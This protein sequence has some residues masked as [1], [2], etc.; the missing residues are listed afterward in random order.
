MKMKIKIKTALLLAGASL[1]L[2]IPCSHAQKLI[3]PPLLQ[4]N[5]SE[6]YEPFRIA[7][8]LYYVGTY[9]LGCFLITT[10]KGNILIN[11]GLAESVPMIKAHIE[12][13]GF[14][15]ADLK[16]LLTTQAHFDHVAGMAEI[17]KLTGAKLMIEEKDASVMEDGGNSDYSFGGKGSTFAPVK[18]DRLLHDHDTI[19]LGNTSIIVLHHPGHTKGSCS[20]LI[21]VK[22][23][24]RSYRVLVANMPTI[25]DT[26]YPGI[27]TYPT[28]A[29]DYANTIEAMRKVSFDLWVASHASQFN[30]HN[31]RK[32][33]QPYSPQ[34]FSDR[35]GYDRE[36]DNMARAYHRKF[37]A[38]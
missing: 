5:W 3:P 7:G 12:T 38:K 27:P 25:L 22:D 26:T 24:Q 19:T 13:L 9:D 17:K 2:N 23:D 33:G 18:P 34:V 28:V 36:L 37:D 31:K 15:F 4:A 6:D 30:M 8:N 32:P 16:I 21:D 20:Y 11:T 14:K 29:E 35:Q 10:S 1:L